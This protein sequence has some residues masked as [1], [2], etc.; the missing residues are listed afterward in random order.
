[1]SRIGFHIAGKVFHN[2]LSLSMVATFCFNK[3]SK[4]YVLRHAS[5]IFPHNTPLIGFLPS[6]PIFSLV[7]LKLHTL[8]SLYG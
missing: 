7:F 2:E 5:Q 4:F 6:K 1:M 8:F 3:G